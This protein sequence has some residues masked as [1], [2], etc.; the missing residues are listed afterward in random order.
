MGDGLT[1]VFVQDE[2]DPELMGPTL[3]VSSSML[4]GRSFIVIHDY[5]VKLQ[6]QTVG[7][8]WLDTDGTDHTPK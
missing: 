5:Q 4:L 7:S 1:P 2:H 6:N 3:C 8:T